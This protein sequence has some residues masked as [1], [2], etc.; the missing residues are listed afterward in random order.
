ME[1]KPW[2]HPTV[3]RSDCPGLQL[4]YFLPASPT[5]VGSHEG[6]KAIYSVAQQ[7][8]PSFVKSLLKLTVIDSHSIK[9]I[10]DRGDD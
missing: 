3:G 1:L 9:L 8:Q 7:I 5:P 4:L 2:R 10:L 6:I